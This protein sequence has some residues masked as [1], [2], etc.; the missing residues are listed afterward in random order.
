MLARIYQR[1]RGAWQKTSSNR[2]VVRSRPAA[3]LAHQCGDGELTN[4]QKNWYRIRVYG[5]DRH[6]EFACMVT[7]VTG[8]YTQGVLVLHESGVAF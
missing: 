3:A 7:T 8:T 2:N 5:D 6:R 4:K 1:V